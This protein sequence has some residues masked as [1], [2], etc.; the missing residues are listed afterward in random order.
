MGRRRARAAGI[1]SPV[2]KLYQSREEKVTWV[3]FDFVDEGRWGDEEVGAREKFGGGGGIDVEGMAVRRG[4]GEFEEE[5]ADKG[6][7]GARGFV[8]EGQ[9]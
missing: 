2:Q 8:G 4:I 5:R 7:A 6:E 1:F 3:R 9:R